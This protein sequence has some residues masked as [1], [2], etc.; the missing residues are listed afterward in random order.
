MDPL[1]N[2]KSIIE[3]DASTQSICDNYGVC[4]FVYGCVCTEWS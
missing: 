1:Q 3:K 4:V 2:V